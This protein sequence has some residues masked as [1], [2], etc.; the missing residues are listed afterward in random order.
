MFWVV[1]T[2]IRVTPS[3]V[4]GHCEEVKMRRKDVEDLGRRRRDRGK[5]LGDAPQFK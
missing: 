2:H 1:V 3:L 4:L 5:G